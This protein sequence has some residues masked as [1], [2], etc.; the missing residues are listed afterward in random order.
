MD[1]FLLHLIFLIITSNAD[2]FLT[3]TSSIMTLDLCDKVAV[4]TNNQSE[5]KLWNKI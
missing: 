1:F 4:D 3:F 5:C 2:S